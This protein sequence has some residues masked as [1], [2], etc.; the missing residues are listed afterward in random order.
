MEVNKL[1][2]YTEVGEISVPLNGKYKK[3]TKSSRISFLYVIC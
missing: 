2:I 1:F 3:M